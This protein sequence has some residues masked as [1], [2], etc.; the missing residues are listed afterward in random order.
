MIN[1]AGAGLLGHSLE[2]AR[3]SGVSLNIRH[4]RVPLLADMQRAWRKGFVT[5]ASRRNWG[6]ITARM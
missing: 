3:S 2:L 4:Y 6:L 1:L 5:S